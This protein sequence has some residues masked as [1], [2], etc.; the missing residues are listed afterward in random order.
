MNRTMTKKRYL[1]TV[2]IIF[3]L[4]IVY[5]ISSIIKKDQHPV[6]AFSE[7]VGDLGKILPDKKQTYFFTIKNEGGEILLIDEVVTPCTCAAAILSKKEIPPDETAQL[8]VIFNPKGY[9][10]EITESVHIYS[11][12]P[13]NR[14]KTITLKAYVEHV[15]VPKIQLSIQEW[16]LGKISKGDIVPL[17]IVISNKGELDLNL[18]SIDIP[19]QIYYDQTGFTFP[20]K[21]IS[22]EELEINFIFDSNKHETGLVRKYIIFVSND[23]NNRNIPFTITGNIQ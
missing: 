22:G 2:I 11:N 12:D 13:E 14:R 21:L 5:F 18:I 3:L 19:E 10:G 4:I 20:K 6:M 16:D 23:P 8:K 15:P 7:K 1:L 9:E 17:K